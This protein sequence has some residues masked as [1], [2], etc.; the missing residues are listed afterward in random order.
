MFDL[1]YRQNFGR[2]Y[3]YDQQQKLQT[4]IQ[5]TYIGANK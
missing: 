2:V 4:T 1:L 3:T 5:S